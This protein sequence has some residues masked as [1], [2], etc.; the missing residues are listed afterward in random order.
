MP[1]DAS[2]FASE[3]E[4]FGKPYLPKGCDRFISGS[5]KSY[6]MCV[7]HSTPIV[8]P[9]DKLFLNDGI[10]QL[11]VESVAGSARTMATKRPSISAT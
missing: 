11:E 8:K 6:W 9:G 4:V 5:R 7:T 1:T 3:R 2:A 10:I